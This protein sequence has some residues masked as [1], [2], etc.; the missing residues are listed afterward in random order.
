MPD[1]SFKVSIYE[2]KLPDDTGQAQFP[3]RNAIEG[4]C[5]QPLEERYLFVNG[6][7]RR[8]E[9]HDRHEDCYLLNFVSLEF[10]GPGRSRPRTEAVP[11]N[12]DPDESFAHETAMLYDP[13]SSLA[14]IES[15]QSGM[16]PG[17]MAEYFEEF[18]NQTEYLLIPQLDNEAG[19][20]ARSYQTIRSVI[21]RVN[22]GPV[23]EADRAA[24]I[25]VIKSLGEEYDAGFM[26]IEIRALRERKR[27]LS[28]QN[29][30]RSINS[31]LGSNDP[32]NV[33]QLK[34]NGRE[35][36]DDPLEVID[37]IQ[38][39]EKRERTL[40][41]DD[42]TRKVPHEDRWNSLVDIRREFLA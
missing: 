23:T 29:V 39:R 16:G 19:A 32:N 37:L 10:T 3:F 5:A 4:A 34:V 14:L 31:I 15:T 18:A 40:R 12:L 21:M 13:E 11:I 42:T 7:G 35:H 38:H 9:N 26:D 8:L 27:T 28:L 6:K 33:T 36:D 30:W 20:R 1:K 22:I 25:G 41:V 24:G 17:A 2:V